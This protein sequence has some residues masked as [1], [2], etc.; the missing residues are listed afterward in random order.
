MTKTIT[1]SRAFSEAAT[2]ADGTGTLDVVFITE[3]WGSSG[4]YSGAMLEEAGKDNVLKAGTQMFINHPT[5]SENYERPVRDLTQLA[6]VLKEDARWDGDIK[7]L[8]GKVTTFSNW[9]APLAEMAEHIGVSIRAAADVSEGEAEGREGIIVDRITEALSVDFVTKAGRGG[10]VTEV[11]EDA[12]SKGIMAN[13]T[14]SEATSQDALSALRHLVREAHGGIGRY[15]WVSDYDPEASAVYFEAEGEDY[16]SRTYSQIFEAD[17]NG[18]PTGL[19][20]DAVEVRTVTTYVPVA[21][22]SGQSNTPEESQEDTMPT[23]EEARLRVLEEAEAQATTLKQE[24]DQAV[25]RAEEAER[26]VAR[27][28]NLT[29]AQG[30]V[31]EAFETAQV[32]A[33]KTQARIAEAFTL[34]ESGEV[35]TEA[36][37]AV[38]EESAA[39]FTVGR[40]DGSVRGLGEVKESDGDISDAELLEGLTKVRQGDYTLKEA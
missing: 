33:P 38:A 36:L 27:A 35:D 32:S 18:V 26:T 2:P 29:V 25:A 8:R 28:T 13:A 12:Y 6:A 30:V 37:K 23:I 15:V 24:R 14:L 40:G 3:G 21:A 39:E 34:T 16:V 17:G 4:Y 19:T 5:A 7:G 1:E 11:L 9:R 22:P 31:N 10:H 20:G